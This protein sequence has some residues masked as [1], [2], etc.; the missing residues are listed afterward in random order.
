M[1]IV[2]KDREER[3]NAPV[4]KGRY[5]RLVDSHIYLSHTRLDIGFVL[6][7]ANQFM[8]KLKSI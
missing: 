7:V 3:K 5:Q 4:D 2:T 6:S 1:E 8:K